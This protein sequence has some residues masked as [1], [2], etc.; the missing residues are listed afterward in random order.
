MNTQMPL[1]E[2]KEILYAREYAYDILRRFF[3]EEPT[4]EYLKVFL[5]RNMIEQFPFIE[6]SK[7]I[8]EGAKL[9]KEHYQ[10]YDVV[11]NKSHFDALHWDYTKLM[12]GPFDLLAPPWE[13]VYVQKEAM[14]FQKCTMDV[15]KTYQ[16]FGF[17]TADSNVE[18]EDHIG[19]ELDFLYHLNK[20]SQQS[21]DE[22]N[23]QE[24]GYLL[25]E[26]E[27]FL[28]EHLLVF[29]PELSKNMIENADTSFYKGM[30]QILNYYTK[31][32]SQVLNDLL[33]IDIIQ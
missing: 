12:I 4:E 7:E 11:T 23:L 8:E 19:L 22:G 31:M 29:V 3:L 32:D 17:S 9:V 33:K 10:N 6:D 20:L 14:L 26:Q 25:K 5:Q 16:H 30:A 15:R 13:S 24:I 2:L 28:K 1:S 21:A 27:K 18:A